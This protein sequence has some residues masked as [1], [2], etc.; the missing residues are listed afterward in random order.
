MTIPC[1]IL[2]CL[3]PSALLPLLPLPL[4]QRPA[5]LCAVE[6]QHTLLILLKMPLKCTLLTITPHPLSTTHHLW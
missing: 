6:L 1:S 4:L 2:T 5:L 3:P